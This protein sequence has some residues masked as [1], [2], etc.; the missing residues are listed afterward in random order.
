MKLAQCEDYRTFE[1]WR[2]PVF[3]AQCITAR[4]ARDIAG[5]GSNVL[6]SSDIMQACLQPPYCLRILRPYRT[7]EMQEFRDSVARETRA[8]RSQ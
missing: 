3:E 8:R 5:K 6:V 1:P 7:P 2:T 4:I